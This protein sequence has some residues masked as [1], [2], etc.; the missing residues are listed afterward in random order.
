[1]LD[2]RTVL[3]NQTCEHV[4]E[5]YKSL[6]DG[7]SLKL[8]FFTIWKKI[9]EKKSQVQFKKKTPTNPFW[10]HN[11]FLKQKQNWKN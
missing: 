11:C 10:F 6:M 2:L 8:F 1:M 4:H 9:D 3:T 7:F 5:L